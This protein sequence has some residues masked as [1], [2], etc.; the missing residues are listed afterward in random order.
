MRCGVPTTTA[1]DW[2]TEDEGTTVANP[3]H[4]CELSSK[5]EKS[6]SP[7]IHAVVLVRDGALIYEHYRKGLDAKW[8]VWIG[9]VEYAADRKHDVR[10]ISKSVVSLL[11]GIAIDRGLIESVE[12]PVFTFFPEFASLRTPKKDR[13]LV[14]HLLT[15]S[16]GI[17]WHEERPYTDPENSEIRMIFAPVSYRYLFEQQMAAEPGLVWNY[18]GGST[19]LLAAILERV[20]EM[21]L[22]DFAQESLFR[23]LGIAD[24]EWLEMPNG[25]PAAASGL[26]LRPRDLAKLGQLVLNEGLWNGKRVVSATWLRE[27]IKP[28][29]TI[30]SGVRYGYQWW[31]GTSALNDRKIDWKAGV[32]LGGQRLFILPTYDAVVAINAGLYKSDSQDEV[33]LDVLNS[34][35][36]PAL[37]EN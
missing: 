4:L 35:V 27:S 12:Q 30:R 3:K 36:L 33:A 31:I 28:R 29:F 8:G 17:E 5:L 11:V 7:N 16:S 23:P 1:D 34:Y 2:K 10:S 21:P 18:N 20:T 26:R 6:D 13:I 22:L 14:R 15:M 9:E 37:D 24:V 19:T 32:G 25:Q